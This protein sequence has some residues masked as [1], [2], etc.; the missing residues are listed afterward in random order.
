MFREI[1]SLIINPKFGLF[2]FFLLQAC[3]QFQLDPGPHFSEEKFLDG[4]Y[5]LLSETA[6]ASTTTISKDGKVVFCRP[7]QPDAV[8][9]LTEGASGGFQNQLGLNESI[10]ENLS[11]GDSEMVGRSPALL[12]LREILYRNC[13]LTLNQ[14]LTK[15]EA[16]EIFKHSLSIAINPVLEEAKNSNILINDQVLSKASQLSN[17]PSN[18]QNKTT[19]T[20][21]GDGQKR[22]NAGSEN[23]SGSD[24]SANSHRKDTET[25]KA[26]SD[27]ECAAQFGKGYK[28]DE[29]MQ[30]CINE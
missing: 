19:I 15:D 3:S 29:V 17:M 18:N 10:S 26:S 11:N 27:I 1:L 5:I 4:E 23:T 7:N 25:R 12:A 24:E 16:L 14:S 6:H 2:M 28:Y 22:S 9:H 30:E 20:H 21:T 8:S 13:E